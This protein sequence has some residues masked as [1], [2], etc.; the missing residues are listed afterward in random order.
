MPRIIGLL[1]ADARAILQAA[2]STG[3]PGS[4]QRQSAIEKAEA[5]VRDLYP[6]LFRKETNMKI[7]I[8]NARLAFGQGLWEAT[9]VNGEGDPA[10]GCTILLEPGHKAI[11]V[12]EKAFEQIA[13]EK[14]GAKADAVLTELRKKDKLALHDGDTKSDYDGFP[15][16]MFVSTRSKVR[17]TIVDKD[18]SALV[19]ADGRPYSGC[20]CNFII[21][22]WP[23]D[24][25]YGKRIN[26]QI[27]GVQF[28]RDGDAFGGGGTPANADDFDDVSE[29]ADAPDLA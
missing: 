13:K 2:A 5:R 17:P 11:P 8:E 10:F 24:N 4:I 20:Y 25:A 15:S 27:K 22:L 18:R 12:L 28:L 3:A 29:G 26:A 23:Q 6:D 7:T 16:N 1:P 19:Q 21:E 14:W 9:T